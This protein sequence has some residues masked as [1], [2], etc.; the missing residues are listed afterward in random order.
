M[1]PHITG[2]SAYKCAVVRWSV[3]YSWIFLN[4]PRCFLNAIQLFVVWLILCPHYKDLTIYMSFYLS[5]YLY[6]SIHSS[7]YLSVY[8]Y[9]SIHSSIYL[10]IYI[11]L[12]IHPFIHLSISIYPY[13]PIS[14]P[15]CPSVHPSSI[16][17]YNHSFIHLPSTYPL[18]K[19][20]LFVFILIGMILLNTLAW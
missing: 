1:D 11:Y 15:I 10:S 4:I 14:P 3:L 13:L 16:H 18:P 6:L 7:I 2:N 17:S 12:S 5:V 8:L 9:L 19:R 20:S